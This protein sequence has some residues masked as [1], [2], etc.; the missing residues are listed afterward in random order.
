[1][2]RIRNATLPVNRSEN[3]GAIRIRSALNWSVA[4]QR[5][6]FAAAVSEGGA[7][8]TQPDDFHSCQIDTNFLDFALWA[9]R[10]FNL[11]FK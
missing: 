10:F 1:M 5:V 8:I 3:D 4:G 6:C 9:E 2:R 7:L 11:T